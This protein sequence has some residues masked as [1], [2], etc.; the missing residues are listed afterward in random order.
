LVNKRLGELGKNKK[1]TPMKIIKYRGSRDV[2]V[3]F[4]D[5]YNY[6]KTHVTYDNFKN[7][8]LVNPY[9]RTVYDIGYIGLGNHIIKKGDEKSQAYRVWHEM[10]ARCY[11]ENKKEEYP[12]YY[13]IS[14][15][16]E[17]W[18]CYQRFADWYEQEIYECDER[19]HLD[20]DILYPGN[21][22]YSPYTCMLVP[23]RINSIF[24]NK[25]NNRKLPTGVKK[26]PNGYQAEYSGR[27]LGVF[28]TIERAFDAYAAEKENVIKQIANEYKDII[29]GKV[30]DA[31]CEYRFDIK[32]DKNYKIPK[33]KR[34]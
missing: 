14:T 10:I 21:K 13:G 33:G 34:K 9:D 32:D 2:D 16:C 5:E 6:V 25:S 30:Y 3:M 12:S 27:K 31:L 28:R 26:L 8:S 18:K 17:E 20:K 11:A 15:V 19:L 4:L 1:G 7:G 29:P 22:V 24:S 23:Q